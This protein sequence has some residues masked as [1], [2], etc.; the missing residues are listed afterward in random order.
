VLIQHSE[1]VVNYGEVKEDSPTLYNWR[2]GDSVKAGKT[3]ARVSATGM[4]HFETY[5]AGT[6]KNERWMYG[7]PR[8][9][10]L[11]NPTAYLLEIL[12]GNVPSM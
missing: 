4:T 1:L 11:L 2:I 9:P 5:V 7:G 10:H 12:T 6:T 8:P 3:I